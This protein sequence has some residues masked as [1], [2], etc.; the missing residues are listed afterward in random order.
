MRRK[1]SEKSDDDDTAPLRLKEE[2]VG[3]EEYM[4]TDD[5]RKI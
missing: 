5:V 1:V 2:E 4:P 3:E